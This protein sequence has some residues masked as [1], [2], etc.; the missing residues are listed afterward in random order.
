MLFSPLKRTG[1]KSLL[2]TWATSASSAKKVVE[3]DVNVGLHE[4]NLMYK[5]CEGKDNIYQKSLANDEWV[6]ESED[7]LP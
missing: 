2:P 3:D 6:L 1:D 5:S 7:N 4:A